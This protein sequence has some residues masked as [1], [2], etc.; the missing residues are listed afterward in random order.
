MAKH[1]RPSSEAL[2][3]EALSLFGAAPAASPF[4]AAAPAAGG[5]FGATPATP[6][7]GGG[8]F[9]GGGVGQSGTGQPPFQVEMEHYASTPGGATKFSYSSITKMAAYQV[10]A[11]ANQT[12]PRSQN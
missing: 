6:G 11:H 10:W 5:L 4:G 7:F 12:Q 8:G 9:G 1:A 2:S 3:M